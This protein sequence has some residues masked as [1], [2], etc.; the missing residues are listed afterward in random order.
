MAQNLNKDISRDVIQPLSFSASNISII[1]QEILI[2]FKE[3]R[4][5]T[6]ETAQRIYAMI[7]DRSILTFTSLSLY[8]LSDV[9]NVYIYIEIVPQS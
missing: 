6:E 1:N 4:I 9:S 8:L 5:I 2:P 3:S 7:A